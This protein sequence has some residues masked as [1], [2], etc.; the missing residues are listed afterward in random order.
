MSKKQVEQVKENKPRHIA[1]IIDGN[2]RWAKSRNLPR[3]VGHKQ[4]VEA[5]KDTIM[6]CKEQG[7]E[8]VSFYCFSTENWSRPKEEV[9]EIFRLFNLFFAKYEKEFVKEGIKLIHSGNINEI[10][11]RTR[12]NILDLEEKSQ[13]NKELICNLCINYGSR[14]EIVK[15]V[16]ELIKEGKKLVTIEDIQGHLYTKSIPD[17]DLIIRT[18][19]EQRLSNFM[20]FQSAYSEF[21]FPKIMWPDFDKR[22]L[23]EALMEYQRRNRRY[24][25][26]QREE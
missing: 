25:N 24:G 2:G 13:N 10:D 21:Y 22:A 23:M 4:G 5:V 3:T 15:A 16:N 1:F 7:I 18:S 26:I 20:L 8:Y 12:K 19:G 9:S 6:N 14:Q 11:S 17:P